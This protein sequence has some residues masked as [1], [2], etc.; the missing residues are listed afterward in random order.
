MGNNV[1]EDLLGSQTKKVGARPSTISV[2][3]DDQLWEALEILK[4]SYPGKPQRAIIRAAVIHVA[5]L[6]TE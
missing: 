6:E 2:P 3:V 5:R 1:L 4:E